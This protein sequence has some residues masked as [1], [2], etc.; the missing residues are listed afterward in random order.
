MEGE[1][2]TI[3]VGAIEKQFYISAKGSFDVIAHKVNQSGASSK[4]IG[5]ID[6]YSDGTYYYSIEVKDKEFYP[7][8][9]EHAFDKMI[10]N[11]AKHGSFLF[12]PRASFDKDQVRLKLYCYQEKRFIFLFMS[13][14]SYC[15]MMLL[16]TPIADFNR[17]FELIMETAIEINAKNETKK[18]ILEAS[19]I[20][21]LHPSQKYKDS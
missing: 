16:R 18:W 19:K 3:T 14:L 4:E 7:H 1:T 9:V 2:C 12:G 11:D 10:K 8:D 15:R 5:D 6:I 20:I 21:E 17:F 13:V